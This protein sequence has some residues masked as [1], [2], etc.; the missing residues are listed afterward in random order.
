MN[1]PAIDQA[2]LELEQGLKEIKS[3]NDNVNTV[4]QKSEQLISTMAK[5]I[6]SLNTI[7][8]NISFDKDIIHDQLAENNNALKTGITK[9]LKDANDSYLD[10]RTKILDNH[11]SFS[12][13]LKSSLNEI[14][15]KLQNEIENYK[16]VIQVSIDSIGKEVEGFNNQVN[17]LKESTLNFEESLKGLNDRISKTNFQKELEGINKSINTKFTFLLAINIFILL[18]ILVK[19]LF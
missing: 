19:I 7:S 8:S 10:I 1:N 5:V 4:S 9:I 3:A 13:D 14:E 11:V 15:T 2:F 18:G 16:S 17:S 12:A 6:S